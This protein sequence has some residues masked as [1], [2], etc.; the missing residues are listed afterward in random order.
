MRTSSNPLRWL[1]AL[2]LVAITALLVACGGGDGGSSST[3]STG[4][5]QSTA[6]S[7][8][9]SS[10]GGSSSGTSGGTGSNGQMPIIVNAGVQNV[11]NMPSVSVK[12]CAP[13][14]AT[15]QTIDNVLLDTASYGLRLVSSAASGVLGN[16]PAQSA[17]N[18]G[19]LAECGQF[20]SSFTWGSV[21]QADVTIGGLTASALPVQ[22]IG[23]LGTSNVPSSC[24]NGSTSANTVAA[25]GAN[26]ILGVGPAPFDCGVACV[27][28]TTFS[29]YYSC[30]S[31][32]ACTATTVALNAQVANPVARLPSNNNGVSVQLNAPSGGIATGVLTL[33]VP[34][35]LPSGVT[36]LTTTTAGDLTGTFQG[37]AISAAFFDTGSNA[38]FFDSS[39]GASLPTCS[40]N[41]SFY[42]PSAN[43]DLT[44]TVTDGTNNL[45]VA[46]TIANAQTLFN[47]GAYAIA[48][49][50]GP[51]G[52]NSTLDFGL[53]HFYGRTIY[54]GIDQRSIGGTQTPF[55]AL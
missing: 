16:L 48:N 52:Q 32:G 10:S 13:G 20:V 39:G 11:V 21:R 8:S 6:G 1:G 15:C 36:R 55:V 43:V 54:F 18:G 4:S 53:P 17:S 22:I 34:A 51:F 47:T 40:R 31:S 42:C 44:A 9:G 45:S 50:G 49:L 37:R 19:A 35:A 27:S 41:T 5:G 28:S 24:S 33:G 38:Y 14:T 25:L 23:D 30:P 26:G 3:A 2:S 12:V 29:N 7:S 46:F